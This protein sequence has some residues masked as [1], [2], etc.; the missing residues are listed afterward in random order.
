M[1]AISTWCALASFF[2]RP[3]HSPHP[4]DNSQ[5]STWN[6]TRRLQASP[7]LARTDTRTSRT[8]T[9]MARS[10]TRD[11][12]VVNVVSNGGTGKDKKQLESLFGP[13]IGVINATPAWAQPISKQTAVDKLS[14]DIIQSWIAKSKEVLTSHM[15]SS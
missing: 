9:A 14:P 4:P 3:R 7:Y 10:S 2:H 12:L 1:S 15:S 5:Y 11:T 8:A 13:N 6:R